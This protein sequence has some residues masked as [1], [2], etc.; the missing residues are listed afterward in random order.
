MRLDGGRRLDTVLPPDGVD[1]PAA[2]VAV[3]LVDVDTA[4]AA[5]VMLVDAD[6]ADAAGA[7]V[8][9]EVVVDAAAVAKNCRC[10][11]A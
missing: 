7:G 8:V 11:W 6:T 4:A 3:M 1:E 10:W 9:V 2:A 5:A